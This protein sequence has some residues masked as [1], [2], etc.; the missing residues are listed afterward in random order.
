M[1][2]RF[3]TALPRISTID[4]VFRPVARYLEQAP[5]G[6]RVEEGLSPLDGYAIHLILEFCPG[7]VAA[8]D[9]ASR[10]TWGASTIACLANRRA[11][12]VAVEEEESALPPRG[13]RLHEIVRRF[14]FEAEL[15]SREGLAVVSRSDDPWSTIASNARRD[16]IPILLLPARFAASS[17]GEVVAT[18]LD[19]FPDGLVVVLGLGKTSDDPDARAVIGLASMEGGPIVRLLRESAPSLHDCS[20]ALIS[21]APNPI[22][23]DVATRIE[24]L[25]TTNYDFL[26]LVRDAC[27]YAVERGVRGKGAGLDRAASKL[28]GRGGPVESLVDPGIHSEILLE[29]SFRL[30]KQVQELEL[31]LRREYE[32]SIGKSLMLL[33]VRR[34]LAFGRRHRTTLAPRNSLRDRCAR[35]LMK[36]YR[37]R[38]GVGAA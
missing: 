5:Y 11:A 35:G 22:G 27:L 13:D 9:L 20:I 21:R 24:Q 18:F 32:R 4:T 14:A 37:G 38:Q 26:T 2:D 1:G 25:F 31:Q 23:A 6:S 12:V 19:R 8:F 29:R 36:L 28:E 16:A 17:S 3:A 7:P 34:V 10:A 15:E 33:P 30:Q